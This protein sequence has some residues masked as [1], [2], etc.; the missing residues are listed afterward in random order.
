LEAPSGKAFTIVVIQT[1][2]RLKIMQ[3]KNDDLPPDVHLDDLK[4]QIMQMYGGV[5]QA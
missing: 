5:F 4:A 1:K 3:D 2:G